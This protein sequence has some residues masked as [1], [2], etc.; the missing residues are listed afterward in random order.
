VNDL[1]QLALGWC[2]HLPDPFLVELATAVRSSPD[3]CA[4][5]ANTSSGPA[6]RAAAKRAREVAHEGR[7]P[8]L[9]GLIDGLLAARRGSAEIEPVWTG[10]SSP[11]G[12]RLTV[13]VISDL[14][15]EATAEVLLVSYAAYPPAALSAALQAAVAR[16]VKVTM[17][18]E[19]PEDNPGWNGPS[20]VF[21]D[22]TATRLSWPAATRPAGASMHAKVLVIDRRIALVGSANLTAAAFGKNLECGLLIRGGA[23]PAQIADH[24]RAADGLITS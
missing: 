21:S 2:R 15:A 20:K 8:Y 1:V 12:G 13:A 5:L 18:L 4:H 17:L 9:A 6:S 7:G 16:G 24:V 14:I 3:Q 22:L 19:R 10:P 11:N 23:V